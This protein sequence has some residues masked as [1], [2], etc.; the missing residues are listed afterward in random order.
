MKSPI[1]DTQ[2]LD[3]LEANL[4]EEPLNPRAYASELCPDIRLKYKLPTLVS[5]DCVGQRISLRRAIDIEIEKDE[6]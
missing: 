2:R 1:S 6:N 3:W 4:K 5:Y